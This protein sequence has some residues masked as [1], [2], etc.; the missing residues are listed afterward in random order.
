MTFFPNRIFRYVIPNTSISDSLGYGKMFYY[1]I[2]TKDTTCLWLV[3]SHLVLY[4]HK[5]LLPPINSLSPVVGLI[6]L[7]LYWLLSELFLLAISTFLHRGAN[8]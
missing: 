8:D 4:P 5:P 6:N 1:R 7:F 2:N 3:C